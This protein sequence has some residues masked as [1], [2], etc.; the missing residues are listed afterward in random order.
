MDCLEEVES[1]NVLRGSIDNVITLALE[2]NHLCR[3]IAKHGGVRSLLTIC[4]DPKRRGVRVNAFRALG[5]VCCVL[6][7]IMELEDAGGIEILSDILKDDKASEDEKSEAAGL[8]AQVTS[9]WIEN[10]NT[11]EGLARHLNDLV[12]S[13]TSEY[14]LFTIPGPATIV[15]TKKFFRSVCQNSLGRDVS[16]VI[17]GPGQPDLHGGQRG[18]LVEDLQHGQNP[19][20]GHQ[21]AAR[22]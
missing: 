1:D 10:N 18:A 4:V 9:P 13:L 20:D 11:I 16:P 19:R 8:L 2:G 6:E 15:V 3:L 12:Q 17:R 14:P 5:T 7:G 21:Q 22:P